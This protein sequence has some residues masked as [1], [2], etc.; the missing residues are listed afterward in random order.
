[1]EGGDLSF[2]VYSGSAWTWSRR[3]SFGREVEGPHTWTNSSTV[4]TIRRNHVTADFYLNIRWK[5]LTV[6]LASD[7]TGF[8]DSQIPS[9]PSVFPSFRVSVSDYVSLILPLSLSDVG[10]EINKKVS[11]K[12]LPVIPLSG[13]RYV[14]L[15]DR[16]VS[17][18][19]NL[20]GKK[21]NV[22]IIYG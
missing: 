14:K 1:M 3:R 15:V 5:W 9:S 4:Q 13:D 20:V 16:T 2:R 19:Q 21:F 10:P 17:V 6:S 7:F 12:E 22:F 11:L 18:T 8:W